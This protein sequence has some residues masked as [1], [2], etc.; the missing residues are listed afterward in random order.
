MVILTCKKNERKFFLTLFCTL[1]IVKHTYFMFKKSEFVRLV[2]ASW[3]HHVEVFFINGFTLS[4]KS[5]LIF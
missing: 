5:I 1:L 2:S 3:K 4:S